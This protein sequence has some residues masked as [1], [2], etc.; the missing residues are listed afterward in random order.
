M[1]AHCIA[2]SHFVSDLHH[3]PVISKK[4]ARIKMADQVR[5]RPLAGYYKQLSLVTDNFLEPKKRKR[6]A[7]C[8]EEYFQVERVITRYGTYNFCITGLL[9]RKK[10]SA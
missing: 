4:L 8:R 6:K 2:G 3:G 10:T 7:T 5:K 9:W 1:S